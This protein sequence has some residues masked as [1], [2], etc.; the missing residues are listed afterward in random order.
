VTP[1]RKEDT[2]MH[3]PLP[4]IKHHPDFNK[5]LIHEERRPVYDRVV[6]TV[7]GRG[8]VAILDL[9]RLYPAVD[10]QRLAWAAEEGERQGRIKLWVEQGHTILADAALP[11]RPEWL[12]VAEA[13]NA[14]E[15]M[16]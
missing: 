3:T 11:R 13:M 7:I 8:T 2:Y 1:K 10:V 15:A 9:R 16:A 14:L 12:T 5:I 4:S 6:E